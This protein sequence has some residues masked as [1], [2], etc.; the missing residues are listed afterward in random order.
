MGYPPKTKRNREIVEKIDSKDEDWS[1][2][3]V[4][5]HYGLKAKSTVYEIYKREKERQSKAEQSDDKL[6]TV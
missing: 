4:A 3:R 2:Q 5:D 1:F 6:S